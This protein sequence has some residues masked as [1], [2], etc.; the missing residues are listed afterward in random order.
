MKD[1]SGWTWLNKNFDQV[2]CSCGT[3]TRVR[4]DKPRTTAEGRRLHRIHQQRVAAAYLGGAVIAA[5]WATS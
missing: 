1:H 4:R 5:R 2:K 3:V